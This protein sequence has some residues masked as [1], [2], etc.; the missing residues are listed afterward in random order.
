MRR[1]KVVCVYFQGP[2]ILSFTISQQNEK[3][4]DAA[5]WW[6]VKFQKQGLGNPFIELQKWCRK[7]KLTNPT[8]LL[9]RPGISGAGQEVH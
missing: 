3:R 4:K 7:G 8:G 2:L 5:M 6:W 9:I 1:V